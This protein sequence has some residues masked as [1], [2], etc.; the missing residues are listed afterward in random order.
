MC[1]LFNWLN[2]KKGKLSIIGLGPGKYIFRTLQAEY[3]LKKADWLYGYYSYIN[4]LL[5]NKKKI[6][7][8]NHFEV[9]RAHEAIINATNGNRVAI[10]SGGDSGIFAMSAVVCEEIDQGP[11]A[12]RNLYIEIIPGVTAMLAVAAA[13]GAPLGND[14]CAISISDNFKPWE[15]IIRRLDIAAKGGFIIALYNPVSNNRPWQLY[16]A[17]TIIRRHLSHNTIVIFG[18]AVGRKNEKIIFTT[19]ANSPPDWVDMSTLVII[20]SEKTRIV[21]RNNGQPPLI[22]SSRIIL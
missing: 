18:R 10:V 16:A 3:A 17:F 1:K 2:N 20:G 21:K 7:S 22:Y 9:T 5:L 14:F 19:L 11:A 6:Y 12:W 13:C 4:R 8:D 15:T